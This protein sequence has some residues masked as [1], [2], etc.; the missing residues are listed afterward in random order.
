MSKRT[1]FI[2]ISAVLVV[3]ATLF[4]GLAEGAASGRVIGMTSGGGS[5]GYGVVAISPGM[6]GKRV[7][8][9]MTIST[10]IDNVQIAG[11]AG[12]SGV[13]GTNTGGQLTAT[14]HDSSDSC[15]SFTTGV[16]TWTGTGKIVF[17]GSTG[18]TYTMSLKHYSMT[19]W[20]G[21]SY[22]NEK[23]SVA[24]DGIKDGDETGIDSFFKPSGFSCSDAGSVLKSLSVLGI[25]KI[26]TP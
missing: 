1:G 9:T 21:V 19:F 22:A 3:A 2:G 18:T 7:H 20:H 15:S 17:G 25:L 24:G 16:S 26:S 10:P 14:L 6:G 5:K 12:G 23:S 13:Y 11:T 4:A 8:Q